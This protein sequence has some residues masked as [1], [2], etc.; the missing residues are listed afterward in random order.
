[1]MNTINLRKRSSEPEEEPSSKSS[2]QDKPAIR[3]IFKNEY[4]KLEITS[5]KKLVSD[6][7]LSAPLVLDFKSLRTKLIRS[8]IRGGIKRKDRVIR[9]IFKDFLIELSIA[10]RCLEPACVF[11]IPKNH[12]KIDI[13]VNSSLRADVK[14]V[15]EE[16]ET[17][18]F[19]VDTEFETDSYIAVDELKNEL[20]KRG[21]FLPH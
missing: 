4:L 2:K 7:E 9:V 6:M 21:I 16:S 20:V 5:A 11:K 18:D 13:K 3:P 12:K 14:L 15:K 1:M 8:F 10:N 19:E 17:L